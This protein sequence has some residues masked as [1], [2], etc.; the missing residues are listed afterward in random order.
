MEL[1]KRM[2]SLGVL[3]LAGVALGASFAACG[4]GSAEEPEATA[5][6]G[7]TAVAVAP[8]AGP[9]EI[10][11]TDN[12]FDPAEFTIPVNT[13]VEITVDNQGAAIHNMH[14]L[15][16]MAEG[17][18]F[19]SDSIVRP[20]TLSTFTVKFTK[21]GTYDFVCDFHLLEMKGTLTVE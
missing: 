18:D 1:T 3:A 2:R 6:A 20:G 21:A 16:E 9:V 10:L 11:M 19:A 14:V 12:K 4:G 13:E 8:S 7:K 5:G 17:K 15:S